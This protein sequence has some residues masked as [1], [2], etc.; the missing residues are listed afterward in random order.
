MS[1][2]HFLTIDQNSHWRNKWA[3]F[4][5]LNLTGLISLWQIGSMKTVADIKLTPSVAV[6]HGP[7]RRSNQFHLLTD[8]VKKHNEHNGDTKTSQIIFPFKLSLAT[9]EVS[10]AKRSVKWTIMNVNR[11]CV[12]TVERV[13]TVSACSLE[14]NCFRNT[15]F[16]KDWN[17]CKRAH[18]LQSKSEEVG[19]N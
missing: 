18:K 16:E 13:K 11:S 15:W 1:H 4:Q 14:K 7:T 10:K 6:M 3:I 8:D 9:E 12:I 5:T 17:H 19:S 2:T